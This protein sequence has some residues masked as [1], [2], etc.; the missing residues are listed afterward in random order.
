MS[1]MLRL[2]G[3]R[4]T[5]LRVLPRGPG[6][7]VGLVIAALVA[8]SCTAGRHD[9]PAPPTSGAQASAVHSPPAPSAASNRLAAER[10][11]GELLALASV[12]VPSVPVQVAPGHLSGPVMGEPMVESKIVRSRVWRVE[13]PLDR[14][15]R[16]VR[17]HPPHAGASSGSTTGSGPGYRLG[18]Y[19]YSFGV[20]KG[21]GIASADLQIGVLSDGPRQSLI[22]A[23]AVVLWLDPVP[24]HDPGIGVRRHIA[25]TACPPTDRSFQDVSNPAI[26]GLDH[27]LLPEG[28]PTGGLVCA[29]EGMN[30]HPF[31]L[32]KQRVLGPAAARVIARAVRQ[33]ALAHTVGGVTSCPMDD[34]AAEFLVL[35]YP[36]VG[37]VDLFGS[38]TGC[39]RIS[40]GHIVVSGSLGDLT[41]VQR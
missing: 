30:G 35:A 13:W 37:D 27:E 24:A 23:D 41:Q 20:A 1:T 9:H 33:I 21:G 34:G 29:Y 22:R 4:R 8:S 28:Q 26:A 25:H 3:V 7:V 6:P 17:A 5:R 39:R 15:L 2:M 32:T 12:P 14:T 10:R 38:L 19:G 11:A 31:Q 18:G 40:N 36:T 16:W